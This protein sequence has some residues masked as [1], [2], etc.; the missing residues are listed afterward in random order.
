MIE[1]RHLRTLRA[2]HESGSLTAA[3]R[4]L[5]LT[6]SAL[7]HQLRELEDRLG[8]PLAARGQRPLRF[9]SAGHRL[10]EL[11]E[12]LLPRVDD[13]LEE[14]RR[15][16]KGDRGRLRIAS[17]CHSCLDW[18]LPKL[19]ELRRHFPGVDVD[20]ALSASLDP[21]PGLLDGR[22]DLV[23]TPDRRETPGLTWVELFRYP[24]VLIMAPEHPL[25]GRDMVNAADLAGETLLTYPVARERLDI[26]TRLLWPARI[27]PARVRTAETTAMLVELAALGQGV[28]ALPLWAVEHVVRAGDVA[29]R[30]LGLEGTLHAATPVQNL[31]LPYVADCIGLLSGQTTGDRL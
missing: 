22:L 30:P 12:A 16:A 1:I 14:L 20:V 29:A 31:S 23:L 19:R 13:T 21:L 24:V 11:A 28:S 27:E 17:E 18:L 2:L 10:L 25:S 9:T 15:L 5:H 7:S 3:A 6:Q 26:F 8:L 4:R